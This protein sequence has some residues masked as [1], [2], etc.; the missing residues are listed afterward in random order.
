[1]SPADS[2]RTSRM[3]SILPIVDELG[4]LLA[5]HLDRRLVRHLGDD[6]AAG[7]RASSTIS[8]TRAHADRAAPGAVRLADPDAG[9][10]SV[11]PV[12][13]SGPSTNC[14]R[15]SIVASGW[16]MRC[17]VA[18]MT[19]RRL[20][21][22]MFVAMP[23]AMPP[24]PLT[25]RFGKRAGSTSGSLVLTVV[26]LA[27]VD[28]LLV[29]LAEQFHRELRE[30]R[31][32]VARRGRAVGGVG[33]TEV[34]VPVDQRVAQREV[35]GHAHERVVDRL[36]AVRV[37]VRHHVADRVRGLAVLAIGPHALVVHA[38]EDPALHR[39][40]PVARVGQRARRD[41]R[42]RVV[43]EGAFHLLLDL[44]R[45]DVAERR[46]RFVGH[47]RPRVRGV[48]LEDDRIRCRGS[49][50]LWRSAW[51]NPRRASTSSP[52]SVENISSAIA[53]SSTRHLQ[54]RAR[55]RGPSSSRRAPASPSRRDP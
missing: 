34:P 7:R 48:G 1:M 17:S 29:D 42:H 5:D 50:R 49:A 44:D 33:R 40:Q 30:A 41:D 12:G 53:A 4:D 25:S 45:F 32:G 35:L 52:I 13:K 26:R 2:L 23:T 11:A 10:G 15:S 38:V 8:A 55:S 47:A 24:P 18:S 21:G 46:Q 51:M 6:D 3:P 9:R 36:V 31:F 43:Q 39:L 27:E 14:I 37:V 28:G 19:S 20:C 54:Q 16:S 22:G